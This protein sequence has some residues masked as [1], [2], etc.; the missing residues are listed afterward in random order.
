MVRIAFS[1][2]SR[3]SWSSRGSAGDDLLREPDVLPAERVDGVGL[4]LLGD[5]AHLG[6]H[7]LQ[8]LQLGVEGGDGVVGHGAILRSRRAVSRS[9][10]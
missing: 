7:A 9:G 8:I 4:H 2:T 5:A 1:S 3:C 10:R 6:D